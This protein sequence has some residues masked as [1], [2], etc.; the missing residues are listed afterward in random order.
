MLYSK[1]R[2]NSAMRGWHKANYLLSTT[3]SVRATPQTMTSDFTT[4]C[5]VSWIASRVGVL[6]LRRYIH[7]RDA[8]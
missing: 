7:K 1:W 4:H 3:L 6:V 8:A 5:L 2:D